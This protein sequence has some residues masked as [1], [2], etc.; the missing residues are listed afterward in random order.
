MV[1]ETLL[2]HLD[3]ASLCLGA[4][5]LA[6]GFIDID[7]LS[8]GLLNLIHQGNSKEILYFPV[9]ESDVKGMKQW[10]KI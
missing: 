4:P 3:L 5:T 8:P 9:F 7:M 2:S 6:A 1:L 10:Q